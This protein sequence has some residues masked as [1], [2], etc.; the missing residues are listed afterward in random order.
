MLTTRWR[1]R[2]CSGS[3]IAAAKSPRSASSTCRPSGAEI[4]QPE[5]RANDVDP[6]WVGDTLYF[7][8]DRD[9]EFNLYAFD[10]KG[11][12]VS[13]IT[14]H[15]DFPVL[16]VTAGGG[17][18]VYEQAGYLHLLDPGWQVASA[19]L[20]RSL[21][22]RETRERFVSGTKWIRTASLSPSGVRAVFDFRGDIVMVPAE[23]GDDRNL[24]QTSGIHERS[25]AWSPD[26]TRIAYFSDK[27]GEYHCSSVAGRQRRAAALTVE[28]HGFYADPV[29]S[30]DSQKL[31][32]TRQF[33]VDLDQHPLP[34]R[35]PCPPH[36]ASE[37][38]CP[39]TVHGPIARSS[40]RAPPAPPSSTC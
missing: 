32:Y 17:H 39:D 30:P 6:I 37:A 15:T 2:S 23:K 11:S 31:S 1:R 22:S 40:S 12:A 14:R 38:D 21:G 33:T 28:G 10:A 7:R 9:G 20:Y 26:R 4:P 25:P 19:D 27:S 29:W 5:S 36:V 16:N 3:T 8:S 34:Q 18:I 24:T 35:L 13:E